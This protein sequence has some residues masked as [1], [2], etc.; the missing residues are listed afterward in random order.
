MLKLG[1]AGA[2]ALADGPM[3]FRR[4]DTNRDVPRGRGRGKGPFRNCPYLARLRTHAEIVA[5][6]VMQR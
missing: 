5:L 4:S 3:A 1:N 2:G 6:Q